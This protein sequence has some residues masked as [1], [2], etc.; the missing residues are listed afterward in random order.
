MINPN[1]YDI[2]YIDAIADF[3]ADKPAEQRAAL[4]AQYGRRPGGATTGDRARSR[5]RPPCSRA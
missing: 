5:R 2:R 3:A 1:R 4:L